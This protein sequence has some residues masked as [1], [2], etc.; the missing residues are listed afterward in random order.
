MLTPV[1]NE[2]D[3]ILQMRPNSM[4]RKES[5]SRLSGGVGRRKLCCSL[6]VNNISYTRFYILRICQTV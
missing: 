4:S 1:A 3:L 2:F 5:F 6:A